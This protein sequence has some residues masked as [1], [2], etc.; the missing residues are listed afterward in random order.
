MK[1]FGN[2]QKS[3]DYG[4]TTMLPTVPRQKKNTSA[5]RAGK[6]S[7]HVAGKTS[8]ATKKQTASRSSAQAQT[9]A[10]AQ[11]QNSTK[12]SK[13]AAKLPLTRKQKIRRSILIVALLLAI[14]L[15]AAAFWFSSVRAPA[16][17][18]KAANIS[19]G[20]SDTTAQDGTGEVGERIADYF[21]FVVGAVDID[22]TRTDSLMV[23]GFDTKNKEINVLN[24]PRDTMTNSS[25]VGA[26]KKINAAYGTKGGIETTKSN[27]EDVIGFVPDYYMIVNF[28]GIADIV[29]AIGGVDYEIPFRM[30]Y[31]DPSQGLSID[32]EP[33]M[34]HLDG[35][36]VV[37]FLRW[38]KNAHGVS[39]GASGYTGG[40]EERIA[41]Q[42]E[43]LKYLASQVLSV[44]NASKIPAIAKAVFANVK[45]DFDWGEIL[46][47]GTQ[48]SGI[49][50]EN[51][52][53]FTLPGYSAYSY[54]GTSSYLSF[55]F[56]NE[57]K[58]L[59]LVNE[60]FNPYT[61]EITNLNVVSGPDKKSESSSSSS[62]SDSSDSTDT[63]EDSSDTTDTQDTASD[64]D[65]GLVDPENA[66]DGAEQNTDGDTSTTD[67]DAE[68]T[69]PS[70]TNPA[71]ATDT[72]NP[73]DAADTASDNTAAEAAANTETQ[74][75]TPTT[76]VD[77]EA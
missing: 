31:Q 69:T 20:A 11:S 54:A 53:M 71:D 70:D 51:I 26:S 6:N 46:W 45:T 27:L 64:A 32:F 44:S 48:A 49:G 57:T 15:G 8:T 30:Y 43:F 16:T 3:K 42:Q 50:T 1:L 77:P 59:E 38:R 9:R 55:Y 19:G 40:D 37:E 5:A 75:T 56:P 68:P 39:T 67:P 63:D 7:K 17:P 13:K 33:G 28:Q 24:I 18:V 76:S 34:T 72:T 22:E 36:Q 23:V 73:A 60:Y 2:S 29:D 66:A 21:T 12:R 74:T 41:K 65:S 25:R 47:M 61:T 35:E 14:G 4:E 62:A 52:Q 10:N 58:T